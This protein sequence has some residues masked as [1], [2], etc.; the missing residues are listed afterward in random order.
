[1]E[2]EIARVIVSG[3]E[4]ALSFWDSQEFRGWI[5]QIRILKSVS[6]CR[7]V[8]ET[9]TGMQPKQ[10]QNTDNLRQS[11]AERFPKFCHN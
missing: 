8:S 3:N 2:K 10:I 1:M 7:A 5:S 9:L 4:V 11:E 6:L